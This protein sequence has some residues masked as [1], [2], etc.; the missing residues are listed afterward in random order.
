MQLDLSN[1]RAGVAQINFDSKMPI[2]SVLHHHNSARVCVHSQRQLFHQSLA[3]VADRLEALSEY[4]ATQ[5]IK[6]RWC[7][8]TQWSGTK[9]I[10]SKRTLF[11][12]LLSWGISQRWILVRAR[13]SWARLMIFWGDIWG[14]VF[15][16]VA[17]QL[18]Y[19]CRSRGSWIG[20]RTIWT[21]GAYLILILALRSC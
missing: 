2:F 5:S 16:W 7:S 12:A 8:V 4:R 15:A 9:A 17:D 21:L 11:V 10:M 1:V 20:L 14:G 19:C 6:Y 3:S 18:G 13:A